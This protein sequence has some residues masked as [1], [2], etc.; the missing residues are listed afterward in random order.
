M[1]LGKFTR[2]PDHPEARKL[3]S[4]RP[5]RVWN[6]MK[7]LWKLFE[8]HLVQER[9]KELHKLRYNPPTDYQKRLN[10]VDQD[11]TKSMLASENSWETIHWNMRGL[12]RS[13]RIT[14]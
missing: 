8:A 13:R 9:V 4:K 12:Q 7:V 10:A 11:I 1:L 2:D 6:Y 3:Q 5:V 14:T